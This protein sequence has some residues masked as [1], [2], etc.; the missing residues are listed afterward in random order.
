MSPM[1]SGRLVLLDALL[2]SLLDD[3]KQLLQTDVIKGFF[4]FS[5]SRLRWRWRCT[6]LQ[7]SRKVAVTCWRSGDGFWVLRQGRGLLEREMAVDR[8]FWQKRSQAFE[9]VGSVCGEGEG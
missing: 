6:A 8:I 7:I 2:R 1:A 3:R 9:V 5:Q 4:G